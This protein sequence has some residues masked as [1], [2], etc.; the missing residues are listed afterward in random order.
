MPS[1][2]KI[3]ETHFSFNEAAELMQCGAHGF[4]F[5]NAQ[6]ALFR[7][8]LDANN[9]LIVSQIPSASRKA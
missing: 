8:T 5:E 7:V 9:R 4:N 1:P 3:K 2:K 6:G